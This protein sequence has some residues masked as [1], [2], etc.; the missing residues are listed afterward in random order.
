M[1]FPPAAVIFDLDGCLVDSE[2]L[3]IGAIVDELHDMGMS[4]VTYE[5]VR[6]RFLGVSMR[7]ICEKLTQSTDQ[8]DQ[9]DFV[10]RVEARL[11]RRFL[12]HLK[13]IDGAVD[14]LEIL[15]NHDIPIAIATGGSIRRMTETLEISGLAPW[16]DGVAFSADQVEHGKPAPD[17]FLYAAQNLGVP[18]EACVVL[19]DSPHGIEGALAAG[20]RAIG[21]VGGAHLDDIRDTHKKLLVSKGADTVAQSMTAVIEAMLPSAMINR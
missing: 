21:F 9:Q 4:D 8:L 13:Q 6:N 2:T 3:S 17:L 16:F 10:T 18:A 12:T 15:K 5:D 14:L 1:T 19:E 11:L 20:M 7:V